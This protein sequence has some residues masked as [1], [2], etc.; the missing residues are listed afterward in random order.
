MNLS[1]YLFLKTFPDIAQ[2]V[3]YYYCT[4]CISLLD[5]N[6]RQSKDCPKCYCNNVK[7]VLKRNGNLFVY[8][9]IAK[10]LQQLLSS[11]VFH[12]LQR[13]CEDNNIL[14]DVTSGKIGRWLKIKLYQVLI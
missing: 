14:S 2:L 11:N 6:G 5:F 10:Q 12:K 13:A 3:T 1:K 8:F 9:P 4:K 7:S